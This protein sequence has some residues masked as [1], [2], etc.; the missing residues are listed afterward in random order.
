MEEKE[1]T[2][3]PMD[4]IALVAFFFNLFC[5]ACFVLLTTKYVAAPTAATTPNPVSVF[6]PK[7]LLFIIIISPFFVFFYSFLGFSMDFRLIINFCQKP[8]FFKKKLIKTY[9]KLIN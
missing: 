1:S 4:L 3:L 2:T 6:F 5:F 7:I 9:K 8:I